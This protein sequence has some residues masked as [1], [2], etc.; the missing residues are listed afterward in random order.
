ME[1]TQFTHALQL[2]GP[3]IVLTVAIIFAA[4]W[5]IFAPRQ[6][7]MTPIVSIV[8]LIVATVML[9]QQFSLP[10]RQLLFA[11]GL[12]TVDKLTACFGMMACVFGVIVVL[13][14]MGYEY[15]FGENRGEYYAL[16]L[17]SILAVVLCA[18]STDLVMLFVSLETLTLAGVLLSGF[19]KRDRKSNEASLKYLLSTAA[20]TATFLYGLSFLYGLGVSTNYYELQHAMAIK[21]TAPSIV[22]ILV[23]ILMLSV[24]GF[25]LSMVPFHMW[26]PDVYEGAPTP[27]TAYLSVISKLGGFVVAIRLLLVVFGASVNSWIPVLAIL[28]I[29]SMIIGN[30][31]ALAQTSLKRMLAYSSIAHVGYILIGLI[32]NSEAGLSALVFYLIVYGFMNLGAF[33]GAVLIENETGSDNIDDM[34]GLIRKR[35]WLAVGLGVCLLNLG[36]L[37]VPPAGFLAKVFVF[38]SGFQMGTPLGYWLV[39]IAL[40]TSVPAIYYYSRVVIAMVVKEPSERVA[41]LDDR[42]YAP[43]ESGAP[44][45]LALALSVAGIIAGTVLVNSLMN[46]SA[47]AV[48]G[49]AKGGAPIGSLPGHGA[50]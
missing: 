1:P 35:P 28:A 21:A 4:L 32:A 46:F 24:I 25:K 11:P 33:T 27:V 40:A 38:W 6:T 31:V 2:L 8:L 47:L 34:S 37:P 43:P 44:S 15:H 39:I 45:S 49:L 7:A 14:T 16:L 12:F 18:G 48:A 50:Q 10:D 13:M 26:A 42:V 36:G 22:V 5:N 20:T 23:L 3:E 41:S 29:L 30:F 9:G 19:S 17:A